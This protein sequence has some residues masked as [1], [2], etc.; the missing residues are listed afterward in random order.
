MCADEHTPMD[1]RLRN[2]SQ[3]QVD[4]HRN[5]SQKQVDAHR[6]RGRPGVRGC[7][8]GGTVGKEGGNGH[9][10]GHAVVGRVGE[11]GVP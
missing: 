7:G 4:A 9:T 11:G 2:T 8:V 5:T 3:K 1:N 6:K 10:V